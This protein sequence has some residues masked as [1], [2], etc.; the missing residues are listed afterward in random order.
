MSDAMDPTFYRS[1]SEAASAPAERLAY[2]AA[3]DRAAQQPDAL[4]VLDV[5]PESDRYGRVVGWVDSP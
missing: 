1:P 4:T 3:F 2:V 5:D